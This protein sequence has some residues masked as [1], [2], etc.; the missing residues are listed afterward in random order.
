MNI[1]IRAGLVLCF[2]GLFCPA[3]A[4]QAPASTGLVCEQPVYD[5]GTISAFSIKH[6]FILKNSADVPVTIV[7]VLKT[8]SC[9]SARLA[10][11]TL[12][13]GERTELTIKFSL[14]N[15]V[16]RQRKTVYVF[17]DCKETPMVQLVVKGLVTRKAVHRA[18]P[19]KK[20]I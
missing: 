5:Y 10:K 9:V 17:T 20:H 13:P 16:G 3:W 19:L 2:I 15:R 1:R 11:Q 12:A 8:C 4:Q 18:P 14:A 7:R 6:T